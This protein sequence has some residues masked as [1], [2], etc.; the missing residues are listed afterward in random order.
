MTF[1]YDLYNL[2]DKKK[3]LKCHKFLYVLSRRQIDIYR[4]ISKE[5]AFDV[6]CKLHEIPK[7]IF[8]EK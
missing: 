3:V 5:K 1:S 8:Q 7:P 2:D 4:F 6:S